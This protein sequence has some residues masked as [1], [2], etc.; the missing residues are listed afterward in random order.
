MEERVE[1]L[2]RRTLELW[3]ACDE[4]LPLGPVYDLKE[5]RRRERHLEDLLRNLVAE[6]EQPPVDADA[7]AA[8]RERLLV[9]GRAFCGNALGMAPRH[10]ETLFS[11]EFLNGATDFVRAARQFD[12]AISGDDI[13]QASRN[14]WTMYGIQRLM[15]L[16]VELTPSVFA[17]S[18]LYP[19]SDNYLDDPAM[20]ADVKHGF[21]ERFSRRLMGEQ[22]EP[23]NPQE[24]IISRLVGMIEEQ[25]DRSRAPQVFAAL[26]A[27]HRAQCRSV[28]L[29]RRAAPYEVDVLG[30][31]L[32]KG[33]TS[34]LADGYLVAGDLSPAQAE[35][36]FGYGALLQLVDDLQD[37]ECDGRDGLLTVFSHPAG[38][39]PLDALAG[40]TF[41]FGH[42]VL[43]MMDC[44][45]APDSGPLKELMRASADM[46]LI[47]AVGRSARYFS[48]RYLRQVEAF[49]P[50]R[51]A[52]LAGCRRRLARR[53]LS[54]TGMIEA[55]ATPLL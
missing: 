9:A 51:Y 10:L 24:E 43:D 39:W 28:S 30:I 54:L 26:L 31:S 21:N 38:R 55:F 53:R 5:Q 17:Y 42:G 50:F 11:D 29:L 2:L 23:A 4:T 8:A 41:G 13:F 48:R 15:G 1:G 36:L 22:T 44:F 35:C 20:P 46:L 40:R 19:Y 6:A 47:D 25:H 49:S 3:W 52:F 7:Q 16:P 12:P 37:A 27:I 14:V 45:D 18:M 33:G 32:E 34:V